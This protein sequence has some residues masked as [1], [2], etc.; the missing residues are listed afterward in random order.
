VGE[1]LAAIVCLRGAREDFDDD[2]RV[3]QRI[4]TIRLWARLAPDIA[5]ISPAR[6]SLF[7]SATRSR[8]RYS[9]VV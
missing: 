1:L 8:A 9:S 6:Y 3:E 5:W 4:S 7:V 2:D